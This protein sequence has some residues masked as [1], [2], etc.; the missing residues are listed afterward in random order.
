M[1][2]KVF[3]SPDTEEVINTVFEPV[4]PCRLYINCK[5]DRSPLKLSEIDDLGELNTAKL[6]SILLRPINPRIGIGESLD[7]S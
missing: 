1:A 3:P 6:L 5:L 4:T 2:Q 7:I